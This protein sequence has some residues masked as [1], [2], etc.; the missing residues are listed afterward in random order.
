MY[1][2]HVA[3]AVAHARGEDIATLAAHSAA[4]T[5]RLFRLT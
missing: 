4:A 5:R 3:A 2:P 1:L